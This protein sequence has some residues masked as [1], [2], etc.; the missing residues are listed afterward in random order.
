MYLSF[1]NPFFLFSLVS[2]LLLGNWE[3]ANKER[4][5]QWEIEVGNDWEMTGKC[6][7]TIH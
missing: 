7:V 3:K 4:Q 1:P 2:I 6:T 5:K